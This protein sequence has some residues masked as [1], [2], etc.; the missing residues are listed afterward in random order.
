[1]SRQEQAHPAA[2][3]RAALP[4]VGTEPTATMTTQVYFNDATQLDGWAPLDAQPRPDPDS[5]QG[6]LI[7]Q[8]RLCMLG[9][10]PPAKCPTTC[11]HTV[12]AGPQHGDAPRSAVTC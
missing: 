12:A 6:W 4:T 11:D 9:P 2:G 7:Q 3:L 1:M 5:M 10:L 8:L